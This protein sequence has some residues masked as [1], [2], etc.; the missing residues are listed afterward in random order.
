MEKKGKRNLKKQ[1]KLFEKNYINLN[2]QRKTN[3]KN[4]PQ[5]LCE[6][7]FPFLSSST[8]NLK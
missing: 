5:I 7:P 8:K 1:K 6:C 3:Q 4:I 2:E